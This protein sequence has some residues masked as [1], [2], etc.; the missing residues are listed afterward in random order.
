MQ[1]A[2]FI[3]IHI[4]DQQQKPLLDRP[5]ALSALQSFETFLLLTALGRHP[6]A[7]TTLTAALESAAKSVSGAGPEDRSNLAEATG[8]LNSLIP[9]GYRV[10]FTD[11]LTNLRLKRNNLTHFGHSPKDDDEAIRLSFGTALPLMSAWAKLAHDIDLFEVLQGGL[12]Q[13][14]QRSVSLIQDR[15]NHTLGDANLIRGVRHWIIHHTRDSFLSRWELAVLDSDEAT[16]GTA[17]VSGFDYRERALNSL[18]IRDPNVTLTCPICGS[19]EAFV[20]EL[21]E[22]SL[23]NGNGLLFPTIGTCAYCDFHVPAKSAKVIAEL[24]VGQLTADLLRR[25]RLEYGVE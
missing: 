18:K 24:C 20:V 23:F 25:I 4:K 1:G 19:T 6:Q 15:S 5:P 2:N 21:D 13:I 22:E 3:F 11:S 12:G 17:I 8:T 16:V 9:S 7:L 14:L 10:V